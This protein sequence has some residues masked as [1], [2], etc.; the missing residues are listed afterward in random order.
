MV[1]LGQTFIHVYI[2]NYTCRKGLA[3]LAHHSWLMPPYDTRILVLKQL[4]LMINMFCL[5][6]LF[7]PGCCSFYECIPA[8]M[9]D[10]Y[11]TT[12]KVYPQ[13]VSI[14][15]SPL[16]SLHGWLLNSNLLLD[17]LVVRVDI[18]LCAYAK[19]WPMSKASIIGFQMPISSWV[20]KRL[21]SS[22]LVALLMFGIN[23]LSS[24]CG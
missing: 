22:R 14:F 7:T 10:A 23:W 20:G 1:R 19:I 13:H 8:L 12:N 17:L 3:W 5:V 9:R 2:H 18:S 4:L 16:N 24:V 11:A 15:V 21:P 6:G